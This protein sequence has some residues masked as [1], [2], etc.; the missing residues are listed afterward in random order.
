MK[1][2]IKINIKEEWEKLPEWEKGNYY[3]QA[4]FMFENSGNSHDYQSKQFIL[5]EM[6]INLFIN[7]IKK[8]AVDRLNNQNPIYKL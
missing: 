2:K 3:N 6:A 5:N 7:N 8:H 4:E 1:D